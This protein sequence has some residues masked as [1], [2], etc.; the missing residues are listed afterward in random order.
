MSLSFASAPFNIRCKTSHENVSILF[1][2]NFSIVST[3]IASA[4]GEKDE[5]IEVQEGASRA[6]SADNT[7]KWRLYS[8]IDGESSRRT[9]R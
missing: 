2:I 8:C 9:E 1:I 6:E 4:M 3:G 7:K 5:H